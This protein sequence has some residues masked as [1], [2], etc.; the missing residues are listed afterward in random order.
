MVTEASG[1][2]LC[3]GVSGRHSLPLFAVKAGLSRRLSTLPSVRSSGQK[4]KRSGNP[5]QQ[6]MRAPSSGQLY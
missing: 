6:K 1:V 4:E 2:H 5:E 3:G